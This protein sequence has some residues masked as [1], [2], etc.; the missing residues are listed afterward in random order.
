MNISELH[1]SRVARQGTSTDGSAPSP[2]PRLN[3]LLLAIAQHW[4]RAAALP[5]DSVPNQPAAT[6]PQVAAALRTA[7][8]QQLTPSCCSQ[9]VQR[10]APDYWA[11]TKRCPLP[12]RG[13]LLATEDR[14]DMC[15]DGVVRTLQ[16]V[17]DMCSALTQPCPALGES[18][19]SQHAA[20]ALGV[21]SLAFWSWHVCIA[22]GVVA[23]TIRFPCVPL[24]CCRLRA[25]IQNPLVPKMSHSSPP[26]PTIC[27]LYVLRRA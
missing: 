12:A 16:A 14:G 21:C 5:P 8:K 23:L 6:S 24:Y 7:L 20:L 22:E 18:W 1:Q 11:L 2:L 17:S 10:V 9:L 15:H 13:R 3:L 19:L 25:S 4:R 27:I 26:T